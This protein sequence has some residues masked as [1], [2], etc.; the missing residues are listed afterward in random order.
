MGAGGR[1]P[2]TLKIGKGRKNGKE[3]RGKE[4]KN[5]EKRKRK[6]GETGKGK[7]KKKKERKRKRE[8]RKERK[9]KKRKEKRN[10]KRIRG[11][12]GNKHC[13]NRNIPI[14]NDMNFCL[15]VFTKLQKFNIKIPKSSSFSGAIFPLRH[16][17][18]PEY[19]HTLSIDVPLGNFPNLA[20]PPDS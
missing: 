2:Q 14:N 18:P 5:R 19:K 20:P 15:E 16:P 11:K 17:P 10:G 13:F 1:L 4:R 3:R 9:R 7:R 12:K 8:K 6:E